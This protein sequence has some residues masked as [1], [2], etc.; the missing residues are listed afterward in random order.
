MRFPTLL[1]SVSE[2]W[3][4]WDLRNGLSDESVARIVE[5]LGELSVRVSC[6]WKGGCMD[7]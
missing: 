4:F 7:K 3:T 6:H 5:R 1:F 2:F